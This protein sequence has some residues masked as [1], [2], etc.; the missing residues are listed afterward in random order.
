MDDVKK[1]IL[2]I[3]KSGEELQEA[4]PEVSEQEW[5]DAKLTAEEE[6]QLSYGDFPEFIHS[7]ATKISQ[8]V[9]IDFK[10]Y[11]K[12]CVNG[13]SYVIA[14]IYVFSDFD[15]DN[16]MLFARDFIYGYTLAEKTRPGCRGLKKNKVFRTF[17]EA[18]AALGKLRDGIEYDDLKG[19]LIG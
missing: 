7:E 9:L 19:Y 18:M 2:S 12:E 10:E 6:A 13:N 4:F 16:M 5:I 17:K 11:H 3:I 8:N 1:E 15:I 14:P